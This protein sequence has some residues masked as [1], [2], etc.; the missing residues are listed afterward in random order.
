MTDP[1]VGVGVRG[2]LAGFRLDALVSNEGGSLSWEGKLRIE[3]KTLHDLVRLGDGDPLDPVLAAALDELVR[4]IDATLDVELTRTLL[5]CSLATD[6]LK[7]WLVRRGRRSWAFVIDLDLAKLGKPDEPGGNGA[8][9]SP[10]LARLL[11]KIAAAGKQLRLP[12]LLLAYRRGGL[13]IHEISRDVAKST[14]PDVLAGASWLLIAKY[15]FGDSTA[16]DAIRKLFGGSG[17]L[18]L[19]A[20]YDAGEGALTVCLAVPAIETRYVVVEGLH[21]L[22]TVGGAALRFE[23]RGGFR[24]PL[25]K[26]VVLEASCS[27]TPTSFLLS[28]EVRVPQSVAI[29]FLKAVSFDSAALLIGWS[30]GGPTVGAYATFHVRQLLFFGALVLTVEGDVPVP[31]LVSGAVGRLSIPSIYESF[32]GRTLD[33]LGALDMIAVDGIDL[34]L[35][36]RIDG[37]LLEKGRPD[38]V[39]H[40]IA[41]LNGQVPPGLALDPGAI[42]VFRHDGGYALVDRRKMRHYFVAASGA[43]TLRAQFYY[44]VSED[45]PGFGSFSVTPGLFLCAT[46]QVFEAR[47]AALFSLRESDG[48]L[49]YARLAPIRIGDVLTISA[50]EGPV[51]RDPIGL[52][53]EDLVR[54]LLPPNKNEDEDKCLVFYLSASKREV[55]FHLDGRVA[56]LGLFEVDAKVVYAGRSVSIHLAAEVFGVQA[57]VAIDASYERFT[58][59]GLHVRLSIDTKGLA[60][61]LARVTS[62]IEGALSSFTKA[63]EDARRSLDAAQAHVDELRGEIDAIDARIRKCKAAI[64]KA[65]RIKA[66]L[67]AIAMTAKIAALEVAKA[68]IGAAMK[69][70]TAALSVARKAVEIFGSGA[71]AIGELVGKVVHAAGSLFFLR[72]AELAADLGPGEQTFEVD[73]AFVALGKVYEYRE[74]VKLD[75]LE[76]GLSKLL[77]G[78]LLG[79]MNADLDDLRK[80]RAPA[81]ART[82]AF[83]P[84]AM[85]ERAPSPPEPEIE[86]A[87]ATLRTAQRVFDDM[88]ARYRESFGE[89]LSDFD[90]MRASFREGLDL[91]D[92]ALGR[93]AQAAAMKESLDD[94]IVKAKEERARSGGAVEAYGEAFLEMDEAAR[95]AD[96][97][98]ALRG[99]IE[100][101]LGAMGDALKSIAR[102]PPPSRSAERGTAAAPRA[103]AAP[104]P[105]EEAFLEELYAEVLETYRAQAQPGY[106]DLSREPTFHLSLAEGMSAL[107]SEPTW[108]SEVRTRAAPSAAPRGT[109]PPYRPRL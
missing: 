19:V 45:I 91:A 7:C 83:A 3:G 38:D 51:T 11:E 27:F 35:T 34:S 74:S 6:G 100:E 61:K 57:M 53:G 84:R 67:V 14:P 99:S 12:K 80:G 21:I 101:A 60:A 94:A 15:S 17:A 73:V 109:E 76:A 108:A 32:S 90:A 56:L 41:K 25:W 105:P 59:A 58:S 65:S 69:I 79:R 98:F 107:G 54:A 18:E 26:D 88:L 72:H 2:T 50:A 46:I 24:F 71:A 103:R 106:I 20:G 104:E 78:E 9:R 16:G 36:E 63:M 37:S 48:L 96:S 68:A 95:A 55:A 64:R 23:L 102:P 33:G 5:T 28:A 93:A 86:G 66:L 43:V 89:D 92:Q 1:R 22:V 4:E 70:A 49:A 42:Q 85:A 97:T 82:R 29:P 39:A 81:P 87:A 31:V 30:G 77:D 52:T 8:P 62:A 47:F 10:E 75:L 44:A 40:E 13:S